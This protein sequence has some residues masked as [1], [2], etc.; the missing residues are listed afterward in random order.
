MVHVPHLGIDLMGGDIPP[1]AIFEAT[2]QVASQYPRKVKFLVL[3]DESFHD[4]LMKQYGSFEQKDSVDLEF[5]MTKGWIRMDETPL[6]AMRRK[7]SSTMGVGISLLAEKRLD[8]FF[9]VG[10]TGALVLFSNHLL[11]RFPNIKRPALLV[12]LPTL[13]GQVAV[14]D[15]G[16]NV[17]F[18]SEDLYDFARLG[19]AFQKAEGLRREPR[20][21]L[22]NI[23]VEAK[24]GTKEVK[25][26]FSLLSE[27]FPKNFLGNVEGREVFQGKV[28]VLVTDGFTGN[29]FLKTCEGAATFFME[30]LQSISEHLSGS[31]KL[32]RE[33]HGRFNYSEHP[34][35]VM[36][37]LDGLVIKCHGYSSASALIS[38]IKG[39]IALAEKQVVRQMQLSNE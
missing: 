19:I 9:S 10:N 7:N 14:L 15:V 33:I 25:E 29:V 8:G 22:L 6:Q 36:V 4:G 11:K 16:A 38:G 34:G 27:K 5:L 26:A 20:L 28:D 39:A 30:Y 18:K 21:G 37:G 13:V 35:A 24:K 31:E 2:L 1:E 32:L 12:T 23:G 3:C 17:S